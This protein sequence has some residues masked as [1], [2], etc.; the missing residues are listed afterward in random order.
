M[1]QYLER[2]EKQTPFAMSLLQYHMWTGDCQI[3]AMKGLDRLIL[4][5]VVIRNSGAMHK[6]E[7]VKLLYLPQELGGSEMK[8]IENTYKLTKIKMANYVNNSQDKR[9]Q[10][11]KSHELAKINKVRKMPLFSLSL[12][13]QP[14]VSF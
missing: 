11:V 2:L 4:T 9:I 8:S 10:A 12:R 5:R 3:N 14:K 1:S 6:S 7:S 13:H